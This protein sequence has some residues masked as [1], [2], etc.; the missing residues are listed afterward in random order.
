MLKK[1]DVLELT[2]TSLSHAGSGVGR[3]D[4]MAVF[5]PFAAIGDHLTVRIE[6]TTAS[7]CHA[8]I[9]EI[10]SPGADRIQPD[11]PAYGRCGGCSLRHISYP[12]ELQAKAS[13]I[14]EN[15]RR[16]GGVA[17]EQVD[18]LPSPLVQRYRNKAQ[19]PV[20][21]AEGKPVAGF[22][23]PRS[24]RVVP[25]ADCRLH[26][27]VF[28]V[29][30]QTVLEW[31]QETA[32]PLYDEQNH[33]GLLRHI[34]LR[35]GEA[36]G[37]VMLCLVAT[38]QLPGLDTLLPR[39]QAVCPQL[40]CLAVNINNERTNVI[41]GRKTRLVFGKPGIA[42]ELCG[43]PLVLSPHSF[44]QVNR[45]AA[46]LLY[47]IAEE[48]AALTGNELLLDLY[49]GTG[50]IGLAMAE[51]ADSV[52]GVEIVPQAVRDAAE[53]AARADIANARF[54]CGDAA[55]AAQTL[56]E[57]GL[58]PQVVILDPPRKGCDQATIQ[59]VC[60]MSPQRV[61]MISC[62]TA[63]LARDIAR[64]AEQGYK[65]QNIRGVDMFPRTANVECVALLTNSK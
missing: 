42:D 43:L 50:T 52:I 10:I 64:F 57:E 40:A 20:A 11:C 19:L 58:A 18:V 24:H 26:P 22:Y 59:A 35:H 13:W 62:D 41:L 44:Y 29:L 9:I 25:C 33:T 30:A 65:L 27:E 17:V 16:I 60:S 63:T 6:K 21:L 38:A 53:N 55:A 61:V 48:F 2:I 23:A 3:H 8:R 32:L 14:F 51:K 5:V 45:Q 37:E 34:Y 56:A 4:G 1:N 28:G 36:T 54:I 49:C 47:G 31:A 39:L 12:A 46:Q 15:L 7:Y